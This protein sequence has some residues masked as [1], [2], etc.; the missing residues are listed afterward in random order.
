MRIA[1]GCMGMSGAYGKTDDAQ[2]T[3]GYRPL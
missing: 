3:A 1:L 2:S